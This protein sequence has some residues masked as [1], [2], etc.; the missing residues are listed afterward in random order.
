MQL[1]QVNLHKKIMEE[2][3]HYDTFDLK[4][5]SSYIEKHRNQVFTKNP[6][7]LQNLEGQLLK[8]PGDTVAHNNLRR[9]KFNT[10]YNDILNTYKK[11]EKLLHLQVDNDKQSQIDKVRA[12]RKLFKIYKKCLEATYLNGTSY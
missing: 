2:C 11:Q 7:A 5:A 12:E 3:K 8:Y 4:L 1:D 6:D 10:S 9:K